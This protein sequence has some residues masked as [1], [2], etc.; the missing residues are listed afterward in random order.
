MVSNVTVSTVRRTAY[1]FGSESVADKSSAVLIEGNARMTESCPR[2]IFT[3]KSGGGVFPAQY[4]ALRLVLLDLIQKTSARLVLLADTSGQI[5]ALEGEQ[6]HINVV[7]LG[8]LVAGDLAASQ[9]IARLCGE[10]QDS[11]MVLR[12]GQRF[13]TF[14]AEAGCSLVLLAQVP[15][16]MPLGWARMVIQ[17]T[18]GRLADIVTLPLGSVESEEWDSNQETL[19]DLFSDALD[20]LLRK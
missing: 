10:Y 4:Q 13:H 6:S 12:E 3:L 18:A 5:V 8:A 20:S 2:A 14:I 15:S 11:Q 16:G 19:P 17:K 7:A 1:D 9:E